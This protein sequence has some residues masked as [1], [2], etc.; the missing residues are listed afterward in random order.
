MIILKMIILIVNNVKIFITGA[1]VILDNIPLSIAIY[2]Q[3]IIDFTY[4]MSQ[5][6]KT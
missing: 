4:C 2:Y 3:L 5:E 6:H 1:Y